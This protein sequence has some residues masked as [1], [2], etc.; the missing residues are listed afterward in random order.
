MSSTC[1]RPLCPS[2]T[3]LSSPHPTRSWSGW[4]GTPICRWHRWVADALSQAA[5]LGTRQVVVDV[6][7][8]RFWDC[9]VLHALA[10]FTRQ[11]SAADRACRIIGAL[12][13]TRRLIG[14]AN[15]AGRLQLDG[16]PA[17]NVAAESGV[18][19]VPA[20]R[21]ASGHPVRGDLAAVIRR[22]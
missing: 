9:S 13:A 11:L 19:R 6:A 4:S 21:S 7:R 1:R 2:S 18:P 5:G 10:G 17:R 20:P 12:P 8:A 16:I 14:M 15:L 22:R 3:P